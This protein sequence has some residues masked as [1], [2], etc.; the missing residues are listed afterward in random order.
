MKFNSI[1]LAIAISCLVLAGVK[2]VTDFVETPVKINVSLNM[3]LWVAG[4]ALVAIVA[5]FRG[6]DRS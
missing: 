1:L 3:A 4:L 6:R 5:Q 2:V